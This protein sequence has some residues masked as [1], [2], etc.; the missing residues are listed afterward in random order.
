MATLRDLQRRITSVQNTETITKA[1]QMVA[2]AK[3][4]R[5]QETLFKARPYSE[6]IK[7][8]TMETCSG[9]S[10]DDH[11]LLVS[12]GE[13]QSVGVLLITSDKGLCSSFNNNIIFA[14]KKDIN[15]LKHKAE[16]I[17]FIT[18][19]KKGYDY[20]IKQDVQIINKYFGKKGQTDK[21]LSVIIAQQVIALFIAGTVN[22]F[23]LYYTSFKSVARHE[24]ITE[25]L[26]PVDP[27]EFGSEEASRDSIFEPT[28]NEILNKLLPKYIESQIFKALLES[29]TSEQAARM[30]SMDVATTNCKEVVS[31]LSLTY[32]KARQAAITTEILDIVSGAEALK[33]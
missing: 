33:K 10:S 2:A 4:R 9:V 6:T 15:S 29:H 11:P 17:A 3:F 14:A 25:K 19:G 7:K 21:D 16:K 26:L 28:Q 8:L 31:E 12:P 18:V 13:Q 23:R 20:F 27:A 30:T 22:E 32:N 5:A 24:T 1:M